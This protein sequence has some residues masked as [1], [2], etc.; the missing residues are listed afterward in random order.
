MAE[1]LAPALPD[2]RSPAFLRQHAADILDF[3]MKDR[4]CI[5]PTGGCFQYFKDDGHV[6]NNHS[7]H[8][9]SSTRFVFNFAAA[10]RH[11]PAHV[12]HGE[13]LKAARHALGFLELG[14]RK[15]DGG[16]AWQLE[17]DAAAGR[18]Q[19]TD[20]TNHAYG[21]AFTV[22]AHAHAM[23]AGIEDAAPGLKRAWQLMEDK[24]W[25]PEA[26][27]YAD[28]ARNDTWQLEAYRGQNANMHACEANMVAFRATGDRKYLERAV[29]IADRLTD[30]LAQQSGQLPQVAADCTAL[31]WEHY[32]SNWQLDADYNKGNRQ[33]DFRPWG[34]QVG[35][36]TQ[37]AKLLLQLRVL[38]SGR[39][40]DLCRP[41]WLSRARRLFDVAVK[42]GWDTEHGGLIYGFA[43]DGSLYDGD[44]YFWVQAETLAAA[45]LLTHALE[46]TAE[47]QQLQSSVG[48]V[49]HASTS[50]KVDAAKYWGWYYQIWTYAWRYFVD[51]Q[52]GSW[53]RILR[54]DNSKISDEKSPAGKVDYHT[55]GVCYDIL[56]VLEG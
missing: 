21:L 6:Y 17:W 36:Q 22:F 41:D 2:F 33:N 56:A 20:A 3:Y 47:E 49:G 44:K 35:H 28:E 54:R 43:P 24:L 53:W 32:D 55:M 46:T 4:R 13:L 51:H 45:A 30:V 48:A 19:I 39:H 15:S 37:W 31:V 14:H 52:H 27:L 23:L 26:Q 16:Y 9:V 5:D 11:L 18:A 10:Y 29:V 8:L 42:Y 40:S 1:A 12:H 7:R 38:C 34:F 25:E 50:V